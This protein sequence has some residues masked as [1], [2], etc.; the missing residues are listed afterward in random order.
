M[1][2]G[3][4]TNGSLEKAA[5]ILVGYGITASDLNHNDYSNP[6][7]AGRIAIA[8]AGTP[9]GDNP[10]GQFA[11]Y[12]D[13]RWKAI[14]ARNAGAKALLVIARENNFNE[15]RLS[16]LRF[17]NT[18]GDAGIPVIAIS[19]QSAEQL[20]NKPLSEVEQAAKSKTD[21]AYAEVGSSINLFVDV[22]R[23][24]VPA[25]NVVGV[26]EGSDPALKNENIVIGAHYD[27]LGRGG[28][29][30]LCLSLER[31]ITAP[32]TTL[33]GLPDCSNWRAFLARRNNVRSAH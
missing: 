4:S 1:P 17:D 21:A 5:A 20:L 9:D 10:H 12:E 28:E 2:L 19:R 33:Q 31:Y 23:R 29:G 22:I 30:S 16:R 8:L 27:H 32:M 3:F 14:A 15:D 13:V 18:G 7:V 26:L 11:R 6:K 25:Y 24:N